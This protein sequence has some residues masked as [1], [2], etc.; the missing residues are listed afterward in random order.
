[1]STTRAG[2][3]GL[4]GED[5]E[6]GAVAPNQPQEPGLPLFGSDAPAYGES[7]GRGFDA[8]TAAAR[9][10][11]GVAG[12]EWWAWK[13][14]DGGDGD[15]L[16]TGGIPSN[17]TAQKGERRW[18]G[19][20]AQKVVVSRADMDAASAEYERTTGVCAECVSGQRWKGWSRDWGH[21]YGPCPRCNATGC[22]PNPD[23]GFTTVRD[24]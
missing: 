22:A 14:L 12:W 23:A 11:V 2:T 15:A 21:R 19:V 9:A 24:V 4:S 16:V 6:G 13:I 3:E 18:K 1:M 5:R 10:K 20:K 7:R 17:P 8:L